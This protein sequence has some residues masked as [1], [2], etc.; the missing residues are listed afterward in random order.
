M[1]RYL[2]F[3][4]SLEPVAVVTPVRAANR[5]YARTEC[6][7]MMVWADDDLEELHI[8]GLISIADRID[9]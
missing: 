7:T 5:P 1:K 8:P 3:D 2:Y 6:H 9:D 4:I